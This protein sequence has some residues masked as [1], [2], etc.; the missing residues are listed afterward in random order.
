MNGTPVIMWGGC[1]HL[2]QNRMR[3]HGGETL[4]GNRKTVRV[5]CD[6]RTNARYDT[7]IMICRCPSNLS[8]FER[9]GADPHE[10]QEKRKI[11]SV[12]SIL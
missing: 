3:E 12:V 4:T 9:H 7:S 5:E 1:L 6:S 2:M 8:R 11:K 10:I